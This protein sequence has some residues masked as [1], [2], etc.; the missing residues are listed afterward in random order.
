M[1][2]DFF[3]RTAEELGGGAHRLAPPQSL[4]SELVDQSVHGALFAGAQV[5]QSACEKPLDER[6]ARKAVDLAAQG[7]GQ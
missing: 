1:V 2:S 5:D 4:S 3:I 7:V 6:V